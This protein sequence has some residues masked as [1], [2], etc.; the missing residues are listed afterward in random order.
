MKENKTFK[1][2]C[3]IY[4]TA[5]LIQIEN[6]K[7]G[8]SEMINNDYDSVFPI[9]EFE[10]PIWRGII[11]DKKN[12]IDM[13]WPENKNKRSQDLKKVYHDAGQW[14]WFNILK[15]K[16]ELFTE[17]SGSIILSKENSQ[18]VDD[19]SYWKLLELKYKLK[20]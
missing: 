6:I 4:P 12:K 15:I 11:I 18:D 14:Y 17:N 7:L 8:L 2:G 19:Y 9:V 3:C 1:Y 16:N 20:L 13:I 5:P 10:Y